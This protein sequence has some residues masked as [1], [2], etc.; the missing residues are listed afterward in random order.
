MGR[1][2]DDREK[3]A[4]DRL[5]AS[6]DAAGA[7]GW[8]GDPEMRWAW[9]LHKALGGRSAESLIEWMVTHRDS[10]TDLLCTI[11]KIIEH[12]GCFQDDLSTNVMD[13]LFSLLRDESNSRDLRQSAL[14][15]LVRN[16][17]IGRPAQTYERLREVCEYATRHAAELSSKPGDLGWV[18]R[19]VNFLDL[20][21]SA[22]NAV[23]DGRIVIPGHLVDNLLAAGPAERGLVEA[24]YDPSDKQLLTTIIAFSH[25][26]PS[27]RSWKKSG[28]LAICTLIVTTPS[29]KAIDLWSAWYEAGGVAR[30]TDASFKFLR[31]GGADGENGDAALY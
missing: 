21:D 16:E 26:N 10:S 28:E 4:I 27:S 14:D 8:S 23:R 2:R 12:I 19:Q 29:W 22:V 31:S 6:I 24:G 11:L 17:P 15:A 1:A 5:L 30:L 7:N 3:E 20:R 18:P 9:D 13:R 25:V